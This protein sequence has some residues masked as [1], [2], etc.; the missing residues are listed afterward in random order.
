LLSQ[1]L[2]NLGMSVTQYQWP[3]GADIVDVFVA[4]YVVYSGATPT[5]YKKRIATDGFKGSHRAVDAARHKFDGFFI[6]L[7]RSGMF[8]HKTN[9]PP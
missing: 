2:H 9:P 6:K 5:L 1:N 3:P 8:L 7:L 4:I